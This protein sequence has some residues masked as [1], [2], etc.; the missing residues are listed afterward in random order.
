MAFESQSEM[1]TKSKYAA[2]T[3]QYSTTT[4]REM[5]TV[6]TKWQETLREIKYA[7]TTKDGW[8]GDY[9]CEHSTVLS[10]VDS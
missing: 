9:V 3:G 4:S 6:T 10:A 8:I 7:F 5:G 1:E 2:E